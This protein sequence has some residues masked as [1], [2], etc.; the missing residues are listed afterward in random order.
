MKTK[1]D[2]FMDF[3]ISPKGIF[4]L[5]LIILAFTIGECVNWPKELR[6]GVM[7]RL[8]EMKDT[9]TEELS[10]LSKYLINTNYGQFEHYDTQLINLDKRL[11]KLENNK[12]N[13]KHGNWS[14]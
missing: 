11:Q 8:Q 7:I 1:A 10:K 3:L 6:G 2:T 13:T 4:C 12:H 5:M 9:Q 14:W